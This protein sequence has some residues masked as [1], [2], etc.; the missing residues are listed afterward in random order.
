MDIYDETYK[1]KINIL[2]LKLVKKDPQQNYYKET[3]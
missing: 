1:N 3:I 2:L